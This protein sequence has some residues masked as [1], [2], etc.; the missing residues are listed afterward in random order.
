MFGDF[1]SSVQGAVQW[2]YGAE[3]VLCPQSEK[4]AAFA[5]I[6]AC[7]EKQH[8]FHISVQ[9]S[10]VAH[11]SEL[12]LLQTLR[13]APCGTPTRPGPSSCTDW[14][15]GKNWSRCPRAAC[16]SLSGSWMRLWGPNVEPGCG[17]SECIFRPCVGCRTKCSK[18]YEHRKI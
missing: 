16:V 7:S 2:M 10:L 1:E 12:Y 8:F 13:S 11:I 5:V 6:Q 15:R 9:E 14:V 17:P 18:K 4:Q 3:N